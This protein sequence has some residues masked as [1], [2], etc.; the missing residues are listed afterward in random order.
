MKA[1]II[2]SGTELL[3]GEVVD[4]NTP[5]IA[6]Q[7]AQVGISV[8][9]HST[10]G[11]NPERL[12]DTIVQAENRSDIVVVS[13]GLGPTQDD[14]TKDILAEHIGLKLIIDPVSLEKIKR[15]Y[16]KE[17]VSKENQHQ[18]LVIEDSHIL[19]NNIGMAAGIFLEKNNQYYI[20]LPGPPNEF[21][22]MVKQQLLP[23]LMKKF[24]N[25]EKLKSRNLN[26]YGLAEAEIAEE[27]SDLI[28]NQTNPT[29]AIYAKKGIIDIRLTVSGENEEENKKLLDQV[30]KEIMDRI[31]HYFISYNK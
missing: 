1:E 28:E 11:D 21:E 29:I 26:F 14:I 20:L 27:L 19:K 6:R 22:Q 25:Q 3:L 9:H 24:G 12:L 10:V 4:T 2:G 17:E 16:Q 15:R 13:G 5:Y 23:L 31:G 18:A 7:L 30:E 8:Y